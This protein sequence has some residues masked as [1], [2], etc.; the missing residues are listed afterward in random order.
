MNDDE[1]PPRRQGKVIVSNSFNMSESQKLQGSSNYQSW[2]FIMKGILVNDGLWKCV[3]GTDE[4]QERQERAFFKIV[5]NVDQSI[6]PM[7]WNIT[8]NKAKTA[9]LKLETDYGNKT[10]YG[11]LQLYQH[12]FQVRLD[13]YKSV[14]EYLNDILSTQAK[15]IEQQ[16]GLDDEL[17]AYIMLI[18]LTEEYAALRMTMESMEKE[19]TSDFVRQKI[20]SCK[21]V[22]S[23]DTA[24]LV[25]RNFR[26]TSGLN[27]HN[28]NQNSQSF[29]NQSNQSTSYQQKKC[30]YCNG[31]GHYKRE[32]RKLLRDQKNRKENSNLT[33]SSQS[34][35]RGKPQERKGSQVNL[36]VAQPSQSSAPARS[37]RVL[38]TTHVS[39]N[40]ENVNECTVSDEC[41]CQAYLVK[42]GKWYVD[43][44][45]TKHICN[46][47]RFFNSLR[48][49]NQTVNVAN[50]Q[51]EAVKGVG[52]I[53]FKTDDKSLRMEEA[54][55]VPGLSANLL[56]VSA[57]VDKG[58]EV[59]FNHKGCFVKD[60]QGDVILTAH[61][62]GGLFAFEVNES[63]GQEHAALAV[64]ASQELWH[65]RFGHLCVTQMKQLE[66]N[67]TG[68]NVSTIA[69]MNC[70]VC[71]KGKMK[72]NHFS[73]SDTPRAS[74]PLAL[75]HSDLMGPMNIPTFG[76]RRYI[77][78]FVDDF[79]RKIFIYVLR[80]KSEVFARF[81]E[82][83]SLVE[84]Q[85][86]SKIKVLRSDNGGE[87]ISS[88]FDHFLKEAGIIHQT[89][90]PDNPEQN[91]V[92][93]RANFTILDSTS[94]L[95]IDS[96]VDARL[97]GEAAT[98]AVYVRN[99]SPSSVLNGKTPEEL[100]TGQSVD[101]SHPKVFGSIAYV[102]IPTNQRKKLQP[103]AKKMMFIGYCENSKAY[104][105]VDPDYPGG[106]VE[107]AIS[108]KFLEDE[109][110]NVKTVNDPNVLEQYQTITVQEPQQ[111]QNNVPSP[112]ISAGDVSNSDY[113]DADSSDQEDVPDT[114][115]DIPDAEPEP[116]QNERRYPRR[117]IKP[118]VEKNMVYNYMVT[119]DP[120]S[121]NDAMKRSDVE[122]S[123]EGRNR[124]FSQQWYLDSSQQT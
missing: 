50:D 42:G 10:K 56:S 60:N 68:L 104:R 33:S 35:N 99:R 75:I 61:R 124:V 20:I 40:S 64:T 44:G 25:R 51:K 30:F 122:G 78:L 102:H 9:W 96:R 5:F 110:C 94:C 82:F 101:V 12:M 39:E 89:T 6:H 81:K 3:E 74:E 95:L 66:S 87:Y 16:K 72:R 14:E 80:R 92:A 26:N 41:G 69:P 45:A 31:A 55:L 23:E 59:T 11:K 17:V 100:W 112:D 76:G 36:V 67:V 116:C 98:G 65:R 2:K 32:C 63:N 114:E 107:R 24:M 15:L 54:L 113:G 70:E 123:H 19:L 97:W 90:V 47:E 71:I 118:N 49:S 105:F 119:M 43:S 37:E 29:Q 117:V 73:R 106:E 22:T 38:L 83:K 1:D 4:D 62:E 46:D 109:I 77:L 79:S 34:E 111:K 27:Y 108:V 52:D 91:G 93:E 115:E 88:A 84:N 58:L 8:G 13:S 53:S 48:G 57:V 121:V 18:G 120:Q 86:C 7:L 85:K 103:R 21:I 28:Q